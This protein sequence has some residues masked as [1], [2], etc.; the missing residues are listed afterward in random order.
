MWWYKQWRWQIERRDSQ[1]GVGC[2]L[3]VV[4]LLY[5]EISANCV[6]VDWS[7]LIPPAVSSLCSHNW[8]CVEWNMIIKHN[9]GLHNNLPGGWQNF[10]MMTK[11]NILPGKLSAWWEPSISS[12]VQVCFWDESA[13]SSRY[14][15]SYPKHSSLTDMKKVS[16]IYPKVSKLEK[17]LT[18]N[19][20]IKEF[21][22]KEW[23][24]SRVW[25]F[26]FD[27]TPLYR[28]TICLS[29]PS[30]QWIGCN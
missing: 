4:W 2:G 11:I 19:D 28:P 13:L 12:Y 1:E 9:V 7:G 30:S 26:L 18:Q 20:F 21:N 17:N 5:W 3:V 6:T 8:K 25:T 27:P 23:T 15:L 29:V 22:G 14:K 24:L 16:K 10:V